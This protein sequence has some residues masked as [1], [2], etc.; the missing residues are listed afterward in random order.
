MIMHD[1]FFFS[2][3]PLKIRTKEV[4][5]QISGEAKKKHGTTPF[6]GAGDEKRMS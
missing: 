2:S 6:S 4:A 3:F 1:S 5:P